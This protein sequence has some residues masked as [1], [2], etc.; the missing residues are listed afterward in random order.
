MGTQENLRLDKN[1]IYGYGFCR[2][3]QVMLDEYSLYWFI[4]HIHPVAVS[5][6]QTK[7][8]SSVLCGEISLQRLEQ[9]QKKGKIRS[10][11]AIRR[12]FRWPYAKQPVGC[13]EDF[14]EYVQWRETI[15]IPPPIRHR[16]TPDIRTSVIREIL[17]FDP[18]H[19][20][21]VQIIRAIDHWQE[22][23]SQGRRSG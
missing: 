9:L 14:A 19:S 17:S 6:R 13:N 18:L 23:L 20:N 16:I 15:F 12:G 7:G 8:R 22:R 10:V 11:E 5:V 21:P 2:G 4:R 3:T 1:N